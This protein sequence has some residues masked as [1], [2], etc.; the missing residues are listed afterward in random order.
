[1]LIDQGDG[2]LLAGPADIMCI[3]G[4]PSG[5]FHVTF[6]EEKPM[7]GPI[8]P[9]DKLDTIRLKSK[10]HYTEGAP[11]LEG[12]QEHVRELRKKIL[13]KDEN[14]MTDEAIKVEDPVSVWMLP[15]WTRQGLTLK[16]ALVQHS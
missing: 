13:V 11:S 14:V 1:M 12:A 9:I 10:M 5:T 2:T 16:D 3:L 6:F 4:L 7:P 8:Q 15:N